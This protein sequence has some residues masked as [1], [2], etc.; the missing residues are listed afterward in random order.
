[1]VVADYAAFNNLVV[2]TFDPHFRRLA[3]SKEV[4]CLHIR[5]RERNARDRLREHYDETVALF[6]DGKR[7]VTLP[8]NGPPDASA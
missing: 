7:L 8:R 4:R 3:H 6:Y 2:V 1:L 5:T